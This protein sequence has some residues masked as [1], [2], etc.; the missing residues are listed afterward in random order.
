MNK[1]V[2]S[3]IVL[4]LAVLIG[5][6][7][8]FVTPAYAVNV[9]VTGIKL[10]KSNITLEKG[11]F[12]YITA[13]F[14]PKRAT[15]TKVRFKS[16]DTS[17]VSVTSKGKVTAKAAGETVIAVS[18]VDGGYMKFCKVK[19]TDK[20]STTPSKTAPTVKRTA[21]S[22]TVEGQWA[23]VVESVNTHYDCAMT[24]DNTIG[25]V[26]VVTYSYMNLG[27]SDNESG[28]SFSPKTL[29]VTDDSGQLGKY[30]RCEHMKKPVELMDKGEICTATAAFS[31]PGY[32]YGKKYTVNVSKT[33]ANGD[34]KTDI[35]S[36]SFTLDPGGSWSEDTNRV[37]EFEKKQKLKDYIEKY[38][39]LDSKTDRFI[40]RYENSALTQVVYKNASDTFSFSYKVDTGGTVTTISF[41][42]GA[43]EMSST[44]VGFEASNVINSSYGFYG[45]FTMN[46]RTFKRTDSCYYLITN[47]GTNSYNYNRDTEYSKMFSNMTINALD[48]VNML[49][50][51]SCGLTLK[52][53]GFEVYN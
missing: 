25:S 31:F 37:S 18:S 5:S 36:A 2:L 38:G 6:F 33:P 26:I 45:T 40:S 13:K 28:L 52:D 32:N 47:T 53:I 4:S 24:N 42:L 19:V 8:V 21:N 23:F 16:L 15:N 41:D 51:E 9:A 1:K 30:Y 7:G 17:V 35:L 27:Y 50:F 39:A 49:L 14:E 29:K 22:W 3:S 48:E 12:T 11:D 10:D 20:N 44:T 46:H 34:S 43:S